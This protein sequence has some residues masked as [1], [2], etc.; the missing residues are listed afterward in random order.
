M[1]AESL[2]ERVKFVNSKGAKQALIERYGGK[3]RKPPL[4]AVPRGGKST[5]KADKGGLFCRHS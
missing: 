1:N 4:G 2:A 3:K 5:V